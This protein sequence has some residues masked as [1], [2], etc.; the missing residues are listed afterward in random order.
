MI[1]LSSGIINMDTSISKVSYTYECPTEYLKTD[2][3]GQYLLAAFALQQYL[4]PLRGRIVRYLDFGCGA[5]KSIWPIIDYINHDGVIIGVDIS[6][7]MIDLAE[8]ESRHITNI[9][10]KIIFKL[11]KVEGEYEIIPL[12]SNII[13]VIGSSIVFQEIKNELHMKNIASEIY[14]VLRPGGNLIAICVSDKIKNEDFTSFTYNFKENSVR[15]D[16]YRTCKAVGLNITWEND[17]HWPRDILFDILQKTR[18]NNISVSYPLP[19]E[20]LKP[21]PKRPD[22]QWKD[23]L[24]TPPLMVISA[25]K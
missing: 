5:G 16:N 21:F 25:N 19:P 20:H 14:R 17:Y 24:H 18:F 6:Q 23:E 9:T 12:T 15:N 3:T 2:V 22:I 8:Q 1:W 11:A 13:D 10:Q 4:E 7:N